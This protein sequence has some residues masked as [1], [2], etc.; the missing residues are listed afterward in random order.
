MAASASKP[1]HRPEQLLF[2]ARL[3]HKVY[4]A[5]AQGAIRR[6]LIAMSGDAAKCLA[7]SSVEMAT[8]AEV[9]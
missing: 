1:H 7:R 8:E 9:F 4:G 5:V 2:A 6:R 3:E